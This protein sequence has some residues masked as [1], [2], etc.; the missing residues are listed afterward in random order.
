[1]NLQKGLNYLFIALLVVSA[2]L[3]WNDPDPILWVTVYLSGAY[4]CWSNIFGLSHF[5][6][7]FLGGYYVFLTILLLQNF[8]LVFE[9]FLQGE[10]PSIEIEKT[11]E[12]G[13]IIIAILFTGI[14]SIMA[15]K[16]K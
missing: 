7:I 3:Q 16:R 6:L 11:R 9:G 1:M 12:T 5:R 2:A 13:G 4:I 15:W 8:P 14:S 10:K